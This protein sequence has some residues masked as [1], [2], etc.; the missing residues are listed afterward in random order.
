MELLIRTVSYCI[1]TGL[2]VHV[3]ILTPL[4]KLGDALLS[5][6]GGIIALIIQADEHVQKALDAETLAIRLN[7]TIQEQLF[8]LFQTNLPRHDDGTKM[9]S[10]LPLQYLTELC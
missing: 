2:G 6:E 8:Q 1:L 7:R 9:W 5:S 3:K 4:Q 10:S